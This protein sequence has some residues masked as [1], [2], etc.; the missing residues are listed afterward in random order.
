MEKEVY[1]TYKKGDAVKMVSADSK[2]IPILEKDGW[3]AEVF[4]HPK[5]DVPKKDKN[6]KKDKE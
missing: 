3:K 1:F 6:P 4:D 2:L 5:Q